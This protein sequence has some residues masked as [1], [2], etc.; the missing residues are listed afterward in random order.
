MAA[1]NIVW[2][3][4]D[5]KVD[6]LMLSILLPAQHNNLRMIVSLKEIEMVGV[7]FQGM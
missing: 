6:L 4:S 5:F 2:L 3:I 1:I 7:V